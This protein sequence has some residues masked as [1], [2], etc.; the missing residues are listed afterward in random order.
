MATS[1]TKYYVISYGTVEDDE[2][3]YPDWMCQIMHEVLE[4]VAPV[5]SSRSYTV[6]KAPMLG[7]FEYKVFSLIKCNDESP[8]RQIVKELYEELAEALKQSD[9]YTMLGYEKI[10]EITSKEFDHLSNEHREE[11]AS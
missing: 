8:D 7:S 4:I 6:Y 10:S 2:D 1:T 11:Q 3:H 5:A 9:L